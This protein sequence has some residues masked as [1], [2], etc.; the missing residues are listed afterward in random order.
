MNDESQYGIDNTKPL[1]TFRGHTPEPQFYGYCALCGG[2]INRAAKTQGRAP[3]VCSSPECKKERD[4]L[5]KQAS[6]RGK[7]FQMEPLGGRGDLRWLA[8]GAETIGQEGWQT[9]GRE[10]R[11]FSFNT[12]D[13]PMYSG[14]TALN[15]VLGADYWVAEAEWKVIEAERSLKIPDESRMSPK[16]RIGRKPYSKF[17]KQHEIDAIFASIRKEQELNDNLSVIVAAVH[18]ETNAIEDR[19]FPITGIK[20]DS[21]DRITEC[22]AKISDNNYVNVAGVAWRWLIVDDRWSDDFTM[23]LLTRWHGSIQ[24]E[25]D[26]VTYAGVLG[27][28]YSDLVRTSDETKSGK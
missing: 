19:V 11:P 22:V 24:A 8:A 17:L 7:A 9:Y 25:L 1:S 20:V 4:R 23:D 2:P 21:A 15:K 14:Y 3:T 10:S 13:H 26:G 12:Q 5:K 27:A 6:R 16:Q 18:K 28:G